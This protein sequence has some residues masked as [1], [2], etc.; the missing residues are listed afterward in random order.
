MLKN[1]LFSII[2]IFLFSIF[3]FSQVSVGSENWANQSQP[4]EPWYEYSYSQTI[5]NANLIN[6]SLEKERIDITLPGSF[7]SQGKLRP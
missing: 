1:Y 5:Y 3:S 2:T 6:A 7:K 4:V